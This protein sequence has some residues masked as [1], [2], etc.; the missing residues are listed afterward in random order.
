MQMS[1]FRFFTLVL[2]NITM[3]VSLAQANNNSYSQTSKNNQ[4]QISRV[5]GNL[6]PSEKITTQQV[7]NSI[8]LQGQV[9]DA[10][11]AANIVQVAEQFI[12]TDKTGKIINLLKVTGNQQVTLMVK[13]GEVKRESLRKLGLGIHGIISS[14]AAVLGFMEQQGAIKILAEPSLTAMSGQSASFLAG[15]EFPFPVTQAGNVSSIEYRPYGVKLNFTP[16]ILSGNKLRLDVESEVSEISSVGGVNLPN[17]KVPVIS[18]RKAKTVVELGA[19]E[20]FMIAGLVKDNERNNIYKVPGLGD[21]PILAPL[22]RS[23]DFQNNQTELV[24]AV[25][26]YIVGGSDAKKITLPTDNYKSPS[27]LGAFLFNSLEKGSKGNINDNL[28]GDVGL[29]VE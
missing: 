15:G 23:V 20:S 6:F 28:E 9:S 14:G 10:E 1:F 8:I 24:I 18:T 21:I 12:D 2:V 5:L 29:I 16:V 4:S 3:V 11:T 17:M 7:K 19:G 27:A 22:F 26:P 13:V 25:T